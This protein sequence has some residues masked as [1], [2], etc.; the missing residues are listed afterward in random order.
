LT[1]AGAGLRAG[2]FAA[3]ALLLL[4]PVLALAATPTCITAAKGAAP[5]A[6]ISFSPPT[7]QSD[8]TALTLPVTYNLYQGTA[9]G[10]EV[11]VGSALVGSPI[12][13]ATGIASAST[14][15]WYVTTVDANGEGAPSNEVCKAFPA[16]LPGVIIIT[17]T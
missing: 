2:F 14:Y 5:T 15:Y 7:L 12:A 13:V 10:A 9:S 4:L 6:S 1:R 17:I 3:M 11:K 8:G 16:A